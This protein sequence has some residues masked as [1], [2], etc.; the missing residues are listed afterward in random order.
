MRSL[1][2]QLLIGASMATMVVLAGSSLLAFA[3]MRTALDREF[4][5]ALLAQARATSTMAVREGR[6]LRVEYDAVLLPEYVSSERPDVFC[7]WDRDGKELLRSPALQTAGLPLISATVERPALIDQMLPD[8]RRMRMV[9][10]SFAPRRLGE[11]RSE[12][13]RGQA[14]T[15]G[16][17]RDTT[18]RDARQTLL[19]VVLAASTACGSLAALLGLWWLSQRLTR[20]L[21]LLGRQIAAISADRLAD[22]LGD[23]GLPS[24]LDPVRAH[25][26]NLLDRLE[27]A[28]KRERAFT[29]DAAH[30]LRT[31]LAG[32]RT[33][34]EVAVSR[35]RPAADYRQALHDSLEISAQMQAL[36]DN[37]LALARIEAGQVAIERESTDLAALAEQCW[38]T[39]AAR[40]QARG[41]RHDFAL[42]EVGTIAIDRAKFRLVLGNLLDNAVSY[43]DTGGDLALQA[44]IANG[45]LHLSVEN[46]GCTL[47]SDTAGQVF[48]PFWR[49]DAAHTAVGVHCGLGLALCQKIIR[50][51]DGDILA[52]IH[53]G[54]FRIAVTVP[55]PDSDAAA[56]KEDTEDLM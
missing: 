20:P 55:L 6:R 46:S 25:L 14:L 26:D 3:L 29:A 24:E 49:G 40:A 4:D 38:S 21:E 42:G 44:S 35:E 8:G 11:D 47:P 50:V 43:T 18:D 7:F 34:L 19:A 2:A 36:V 23:L 32:L 17:A 1:R 52:T 28:F 51:M 56:D 37:L 12:P 41:L 5:A 9:A 10:F 33:T 31:P 13:A 54:R 27:A 15:L 48:A 30:E 16:V 53:D 22:R 39:V 45:A